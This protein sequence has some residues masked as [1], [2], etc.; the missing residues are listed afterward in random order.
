[1]SNV[2]SISHAGGF[3]SFG[4]REVIPNSGTVSRDPD[5]TT[6]DRINEF[7]RKYVWPQNAE[8]QMAAWFGIQSTAGCKGKLAGRISY[9]VKDVDRLKQHPKCGRRFILHV[10]SLPLEPDYSEVLEGLAKLREQMARI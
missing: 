7:V 2:R 5:N 3:T 4:P 6:D 10:Y 1:M 9:T 8:K